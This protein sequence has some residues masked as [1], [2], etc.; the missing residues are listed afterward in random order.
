MTAPSPGRVA[1]RLN[2]GD[3][4]H[5]GWQAFCRTPGTFVLFAMLLWGLQ[6]GFQLLQS[7]LGADGAFSNRPSDW[8]LAL[9]GLVGAIASYFWGRIGIVRGAL[10]SLDGHRPRFSELCRWDD[11]PILRLFWSS[12]LLNGLQ[13]GAILLIVLGVGGPMVHRAYQGQ[14]GG[15]AVVLGPDLVLIVL[16]VLLVLLLG[17]WLVAVIYLR[18]NQQFLGQIALNEDLGPWATLQRG[19]T[20]ADP[21][22]PLLLL[23]LLIES[24]LCVFGVLACFV[25]FFVAWPMVLCITTAAYRQLLVL[26]SAKRGFSTPSP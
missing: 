6:I 12:L 24:M 26:E 16:L 18:V 22:W 11:G 14:S 7:R 20:L 13:V 3:A 4:L 2:I 1:P 8:L 15:S 25:G 21:H 23:L 19:R 9:V 5:D 17:L 10:R